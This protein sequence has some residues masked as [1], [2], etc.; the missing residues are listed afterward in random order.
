M[1]SDAG[2]GAIAVLSTIPGSIFLKTFLHFW[3]V[4]DTLF[5]ICASRKYRSNTETTLASDYSLL[6]ATTLTVL[7]IVSK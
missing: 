5:E 6:L 1:T 2:M 4:S 3:V 7:V